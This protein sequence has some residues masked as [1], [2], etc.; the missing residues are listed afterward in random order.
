VWDRLIEMGPTVEVSPAYL[1]GSEASAA[2]D[3]ARIIAEEQ[4]KSVF[5]ELVDSH[6]ERVLRERKKSV[7]AFAARRRSIER[8]GLPQVRA[9]RL[10]RLEQEERLWK[11]GIEEKETVVP[12]L[13]APLMVRVAAAGELT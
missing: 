1:S 10:L 4:G 7:Q 6:R 12:E 3:N 11:K 8:I 9:H 13:S 2:Y 5:Q